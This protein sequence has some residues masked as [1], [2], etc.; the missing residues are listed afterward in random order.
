MKRDKIR[1]ELRR[2]RRENKLIRRVNGDLW[3]ANGRLLGTNNLLQ[4]E[5]CF[6]RMKVLCPHTL[7][8]NAVSIKELKSV[9]DISRC[10]GADDDT[11]KKIKKAI[12]DMLLMSFA[13]TINGS[14]MVYQEV[15]GNVLETKIKYCLFP[16]EEGKE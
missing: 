11:I 2:L 6:L 3:E 13:D 10:I 9:Y 12:L 7:A 5:N 1:G 15:K 14:G 4:Q 16:I 8:E